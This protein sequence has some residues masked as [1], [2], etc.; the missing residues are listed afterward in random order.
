M[1]QKKF[2]VYGCYDIDSIIR[3][4]GKGSGRRFL[5]S[6]KQ[7]CNRIF[8]N[9]RASKYTSKIIINNLTERE[10]YNKERELIERYGRVVTNTGSLYNITEGGNGAYGVMNSK[11]ITIKN[12]KTGK[13]YNFQSHT[14]AA[15]FIECDVSYIGFLFNGTYKH[16]QRTFVLPNTDYITPV[17]IVRSKEFLLKRYKSI[18]IYDNINKQYLNFKSGKQASID[19]EVSSSDISTLKR[20]TIKAVKSGRYSLSPLTQWRSKS[21]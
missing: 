20:G 13:I 7:N 11:P 12:I 8:K 15:K 16:I 10:A 6:I 4:I 14:A 3:Y 1:W 9:I 19:L 21:F 2:Y 18:T 17:K 5:S